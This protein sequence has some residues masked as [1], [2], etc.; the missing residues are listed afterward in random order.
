MDA[1]RTVLRVTRLMSERDRVRWFAT[2]LISGLSGLLEMLSVWAVF[3]TVAVIL[4][5][6]ASSSLPWIQEGLG[7]VGELPLMVILA[8]VA[9]L[10]VVKTIL[11][12]TVVHVG[13]R[14]L[15]QAQARLAGQLFSGYLAAPF[16]FHLERDSIEKAHTLIQRLSIAFKEVAHEALVLTN[17]LVVALAILLVVFASDWRAATVATIFVAASLSLLSLLTR[18]MLLRLGQR[19]DLAAQ[20]TLATMMTGFRAIEE[21]KAFGREHRFS[22]LFGAAQARFLTASYRIDT[23]LSLPRILSETVFVLALL[24]VV[25]LVLGGDGT[26]R[27]LLPLLAVYAYAGLRLMPMANRTAENIQRIRSAKPTI[28]A[29][30]EQYR[31]LRLSA[32]APEQRPVA[33]GLNSEIELADVSLS[34]GPGQPL[35]LEDINLIVHR[36]EWLGLVGDTG[37]GKSSI[38]HVML[39]LLPPSAGHVRV[40]GQDLHADGKAGRVRAGYVPQQCYLLNDTVRRNIAFGLS[41]HEID[42]DRLEAVVKL[43]QLEGFVALLDR[44]LDTAVGEDAIRVSGGERQRLAIA[45]ALYGEPRL[46][47]LDE[48][49]SA[50]DVHTEAAI[51]EALRADDTQRTVVMVTH[52]A[53]AAGTCDRLIGLRKGRI[54]AQGDCERLQSAD[55]HF[56]AL[57]QNTT[58]DVDR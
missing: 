31:D 12:L 43:A 4:Q 15:N 46:L 34:Y 51:L 22:D 32:D 53:S 14:F 18:K 8:I 49:T 29:L 26:D 10:F 37:A 48:A 23:L 30:S 28:D 3:V 25:A 41:D 56:R 33:L 36:G 21:I 1:F 54:V 42:N 20:E 52:R 16:S 9:V 35:A 40:D 38:L 19:R 17:N 39:G 13:N 55:G 45:R 7:M 5:T 24:V 50:L 47:I 27:T 6:G 57:L 11:M 58:S 44:G 2:L